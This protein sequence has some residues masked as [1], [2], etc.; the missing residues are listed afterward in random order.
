[1]TVHRDQAVSTEEASQWVRKMSLPGGGGW[2]WQCLWNSVSPPARP[3]HPIHKS[4]SHQEP[5]KRPFYPETPVDYTLV[6]GP[7]RWTVLGA[8]SPA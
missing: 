4:P 2:G 6:P 1:M 8:I 3:H 7:S 5:L